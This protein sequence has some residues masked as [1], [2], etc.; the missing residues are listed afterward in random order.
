MLI[1]GLVVS[2]VV[3]LVLFFK[4]AAHKIDTSETAG[5]RELRLGHDR[6]IEKIGKLRQDNRDLYAENAALR[7]EMARSREINELVI[8]RL[9][10]WQKRLSNEE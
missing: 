3:L 8:G 10:E 1:E 5:E 4:W 9:S 6:I 2:S 7:G